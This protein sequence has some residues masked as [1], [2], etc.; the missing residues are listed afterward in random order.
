MSHDRYF[1]D[2]V[3]TKIVELED[4]ESTVFH[5]NYTQYVKEMEEL[6]LRQFADYQEQ[7]RQ[8]KKMRETIKQLM[9][10]GRI[11]DNGKF[12]RRAASMQR[13]LDRMEKLKRPAV[14]RKEA[15]FE[16]RPSE[17]SGKQVVIL[18]SVEK[19]YGP[20]TVLACV[21]GELRYGEKVVL[22]GDNGSDAALGGQNEFIH[23][24]EDGAAR[25]GNEPT[26]CDPV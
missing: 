5:T 18:D 14:D 8:I 10:W 26:L 11:G 15:A 1:L 4:G 6:L 9:D 13:A 23:H 24:C 17:R 21:T 22:V 12:F 16:L 3:V 19:R 7:Q 2:R 25:H 20:K